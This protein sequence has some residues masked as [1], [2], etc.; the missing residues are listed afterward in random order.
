M[1]RI[2]HWLSRHRIARVVN[3]GSNTSR[4]DV[5]VLVHGRP[6]TPQRIAVAAGNRYFLTMYASSA[7]SL[8]LARVVAEPPAADGT[9]RWRLHYAPTSRT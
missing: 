5:D 2:Y 4:P 7:G 6:W 8:R 3:S 9:R 1:Q